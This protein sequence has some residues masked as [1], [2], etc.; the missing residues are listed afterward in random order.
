MISADQIIRRFAVSE[1][2]YRGTALSANL[3]L[4][5]IIATEK[6]FG[7]EGVL[8]SA[9]IQFLISGLL[10]IPTGRFA[11]REGWY[12][13]IRWGLQLKILTT[14][15]Y[16]GAVLC[17]YS[18]GAAWAW[19][20]IAVE[21]VIDSFANAFISGA[22][23]AAY[24]HWYEHH[25]KLNGIT[26]A[27]APPLF[28][29]SFRYSLTLR[30]L[31]P[32]T[33]LVLG[34][35]LFQF[36]PAKGSALT[37]YLLLLAYVLA[38]RFIVVYRT[39]ADLQPLAAQQAE[40]SS[41]QAHPPLIEIVE[42]GFN[43]LLLYA[44]AALATVACGFYLYG[45]IY[46]SLSSFLP[47]VGALWIGGTLIGLLIN[48][49][50]I[51]LSRAT[52]RRAEIATDAQIKKWI[53][54]LIG[55]LSFSAL[56]LLI[57][58]DSAKLHVTILFSYCLMAMT[59]GNLILRWIS[60]HETGSLRPEIRA[61][62]LSVGE[63]MGLIAFGFLAGL[64]LLSAIP[65][66]GLWTLL[67][68]LGLGGLGLSLWASLAKS[69]TTGAKITLKQYLGISVLGTA[70]TFFIIISIF[71]ARSFTQSS[72][73][74][75]QDGHRLLLQV[76]KSGL[77]E[78][79]IQGSATETA[80][81]LNGIVQGRNDICIEVTLEGRV[82]ED[83]TVFKKRASIEEFTDN[84]YFDESAQIL[85]ARIHLYGDYS[86]IQSRA[87]RRLMGGLVV[88]FFLGIALFLVIALSSRRIFQEIALL[89]ETRMGAEP[90][91]LI[92]E[93]GQLRAELSAGQK[94]KEESLR[95]ATSAEIASQVAH[96]IRSPLAALE[97]AAGDVS[98]LPEDKRVLI[99]G[100]VGRI[101]DIAN[102]LLNRQ[103]APAAESIE[104]IVSP[105]LLSSLIESLVSEKRL[106]FRAHSRVVI[107]TWLDAS[108]YGVFARVQPVEFKRI[109]SNLI[110][111]SVD[112][113]GA[114]PGS[115]RVNL[116]TL[117]GRALV[118]VKD[119]GKGIAPDILL[120][121][122]QRGETHGKAGGS[123]LGL[124]HARTSAERWGGGLEIASEITKGTTMT[125]VLP[126]VPVPDWFV[127]ELV[128]RPGRKVVILDDDASI[129]QI[130]RGR[131]D[132]LSAPA[133]GVELVHASTPQDLRR[134]VKGNP[135][136]LTALFLLDYE[137]LGCRETG[138]SL[139][140]E[141]SILERSILV[142]SHYEEPGILEACRK[143]STKMIPKGLAR[144]VP[145]LIEPPF[146]DA[147]HWDAVLIDDDA[148]VRA[149][150]KMA[151]ARTGKRLRAFPTAAEF[152]LEAS[153][154]IDRRTPVYLDAEL[155]N[156][157]KGDVESLRI[158]ELG[159]SEIYLA[160][161]HEPA[162]FAGLAHLRGVRGKE[163]PWT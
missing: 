120:K 82:L 23:Q 21:S 25:L 154:S 86:D 113:F 62:W 45:E 112:S 157:E 37:I 158:H 127:S 136:A 33:A 17:V 61:T 39:A 87:R 75:K 34:T 152:F 68:F 146:S 11:D 126:R 20:L 6:G 107:E 22:Y 72:R 130:W 49:G 3:I 93:F 24:A 51:V 98:Q 30:L 140:Q 16:V 129:H 50:G 71:D 90:V 54:A 111:N 29:A 58:F 88:Y 63:V 147:A 114:G 92:R 40:E 100:A 64:S 78:P 108:S 137:L 143:L 103:R 66:A 27:D 1:A 76:L 145:I 96:D 123:G 119:D 151:A 19:L 53:P 81:R 32:I 83:C 84:I 150:W 9:F 36:S 47:G 42:S 128:L 4:I 97:V 18:I 44:F 134:W 94:H 14:L 155:A 89:H 48:V 106:Q 131:L 109:L 26:K 153:A 161:G 102:S 135:E 10:E 121:L 35:L 142:T 74:I 8:I 52:A 118:S 80:A 122:G 148:L 56:G 105:Q 60:S 38:L 85:A 144:L 160:T 2:L 28:V 101:R 117:D 139:A 79:V 5:S 124:H 104:E 125:V 141:L 13:S 116:S 159:F 57:C 69:E 99:R 91:F 59:G 70:C 7:T 41:A 55:I 65:R 156:G 31:L 12:K 67:I 110:D 163:A 138:L 149:A 132:A 43:S 73:T 46:R 133:Q 115:V 162:K 95:F 77:R 15:C